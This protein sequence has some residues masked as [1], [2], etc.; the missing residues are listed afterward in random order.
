MAST[1][2]SV[3]L[4]PVTNTIPAWLRP[5]LNDADLL[6]IRATVMRAEQNTS[7]E[8]VPM[9]VK[10]SANFGHV[11]VILF[12]VSLVFFWS[13]ATQI[14]GSF[15]EIPF[16]VLELSS[17]ALSFLVA[18]ALKNSNFARY[19]LT[20]PHDQAL[21][22]MH[23][24]QLE[25]YQSN[26]KATHRHTGVLIFVSLLERRAVI[27]ADEAVSTKIKNEEWESAIDLL[28]KE[29]RQ[30]KLSAG[31]C[32][33]IALVGQ[34]LSQHLPMDIGD[35]DELANDLVMKE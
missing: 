27:L 35:R 17:I 20:S 11:S 25:F 22:V 33:A 34:R 18:W 6:E 26:I 15:P 2:K 31:L 29:T 21:S 23:R 28:L 13:F 9:V 30:G 1:D 12:L 19:W 32:D 14:A 16:W 8:I 3:V 24:A 7:G 5:S 10:S 4:K